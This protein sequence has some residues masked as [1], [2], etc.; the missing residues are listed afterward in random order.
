MNRK[1]ASIVAAVILAA[2]FLAPKL[3]DSLGSRS[4]AEPDLALTPEA[5]AEHEPATRPGTDDGAGLA[6]SLPEDERREAEGTVAEATEDEATRP[7]TSVVVARVTDDRGTPLTGAQLVVIKRDGRPANVEP[8]ELSEAD[9]LVT[10]ALEDGDLRTWRGEI[11]R[12]RFT[13]SAPNRATRFVVG[14]PKR[15]ATLDLGVIVLEPGATVRGRV[16]DEDG[17]GVDGARVLTCELALESSLE[18]MRIQ[19]PDPDITRLQV[20]TGTDGRFELPGVAAGDLRLAAHTDGMLWSFTEPFHAQTGAVV[21]APPIQLEV[22][23][24]TSLVAGVVVDPAGVPVASVDVHY[25]GGMDYRSHG[26]VTTS[27]AGRFAIPTTQETLELRALDES[28][29]HG[30][31]PTTTGRSGGEEVE[32]QLTPRHTIVVRVD[33]R[34]GGPI[35]GASVM[36]LSTRKEPMMFGGGSILMGEDWEHTDAD[37]LVTLLVPDEPFRL[38]VGSEN[39]DYDHP[40]PFDPVSVPAE[41]HVTLT[42]RPLLEGVVLADGA[43]VPGAKV[44]SCQPIDG[45]AEL[46]MGFA[47]RFWGSGQ[48]SATTDEN[49]RFAMPTE[50]EW[51][52]AVLLA[53]A[54]GWA[55]AE[56]RVVFPKGGGRDDIELVLT[57][58]GA[59]EGT[60]TAPPDRSV[61]GIVVAASRGDG[62]P[63]SVR[64]DEEG[65]YRLEHLTPGDWHVEARDGEPAVD[66]L[67]VVKVEE[68]TFGWNVFVVEGEVARHD[69][70]LRREADVLLD[71]LLTVG[72]RPAAGWNVRPR[73]PNYERSLTALPT[74]VLDEAGGFALSLQPG[75]YE[76]ELRSPE[77]VVPEFEVFRTLE[78][79]GPAMSWSEEVAVGRFK[80]KIDD[81]P[82]RLR[83]F[84]G[85]TTV[86]RWE[87][88]TFEVDETGEYDVV[89]PAGNCS[90]Q[91]EVDGTYGRGWYGRGEVTIE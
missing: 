39:H 40:G 48:W 16:I 58:G 4:P 7:S 23:P 43:P 73:L 51:T 24:A 66:V 46:S 10:L 9:G 56:Q 81:G 18:V 21:D 70:D 61:A 35:E 89:A 69:L 13:V 79:A 8:S 19:G 82:L 80:G 65:W 62:F 90:F 49:G 31:S 88:I 53:M 5:P 30:P 87:R 67:T 54:D 25:S 59:I 2:A 72:G 84:H 1:I 11:Y 91:N 22:V 64:T 85:D 44:E 12:M 14:T 74:A 37:G 38:S 17:V 55:V 57:P 76:L 68:D 26:K 50:K 36:V 75:E 6:D 3:L 27:S 86:G 28:G 77:G 47:Q 41:I 32:L 52:E 15:R 63:R 20:S 71:G 34:G 33:E 83:V 42:R 78:V 60:V 29:R 45:H